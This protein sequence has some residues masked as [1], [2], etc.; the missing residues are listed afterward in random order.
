[1]WDKVLNKSEHW[2]SKCDMKRS[3]DMWHQ[4]LKLEYKAMDWLGVK[5][6]PCYMHER[7]GMTYNFQQRPSRT[8]DKH[9]DKYVLT[10]YFYC[11]LCYI[12]L[13]FL[14]SLF[15]L[16]STGWADHN[17]ELPRCTRIYTNSTSLKSSQKLEIM[18]SCT[19]LLYRVYR[20]VMDQ[21]KKWRLLSYIKQV[22]ERMRDERDRERSEF[23]TR[24]YTNPTYLKH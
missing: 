7:I 9:T 22:W 5:F 13:L 23:C 12:F 2:S 14:R 1:M 11:C 17:N 8:P 19:W 3:G 21:G 10:L 20:E 24:I 18:M 6:R 15:E 16:N 4:F